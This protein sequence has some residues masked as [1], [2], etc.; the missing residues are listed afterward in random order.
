M[1][2]RFINIDSCLRRWSTKS[3]S[4]G[5]QSSIRCCKHQRVQRAHRTSCPVQGRRQP[6][7]MVIWSLMERFQPWANAQLPRPS[8]VGKIFP[9]IQPLLCC[10]SQPLV[11]GSGPWG[12]SNYTY[13]HHISGKIFKFWKQDHDFNVSSSSD[14]RTPI[15]LVIFPKSQTIVPIVVYCKPFTGSWR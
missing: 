3:H 9:Q 8:R 11:P 7:R 5:K 15:P 13:C 12:P 1:T 10:R 6:W 4:P 14:R 2:L